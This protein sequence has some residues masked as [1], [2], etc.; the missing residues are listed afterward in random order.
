MAANRKIWIGVGVA[1][2]VAAILAVVLIAGG[3]DEASAQTVTFQKPTDA[4]PDP[5][6]KPSDIHGEDT[7]DVGSG[8]YG[9]T[10]S[11]LVCDRELL[12][13]SLKARPD[14]LREWAK[15]LNVTPTYEAVARYIRSLR[16]VTLTRDTRV[17]NYSFEG[18]KAVGFQS[19]LQA[20]T[21]VLVD[22]YGEP[23]VRCRC[24]NPLTKPIYYP[25]AKCY[26]CPP[27]YEPPPPCEPYS[28]CWH[29]YP[30]PPPVSTSEEPT[31]D[32]QRKSGNPSAYFS[33]SAGTTGDTY[34]LYA[35][36]F[37][38]NKTLEVT[39]TR[40]DG[41]VE[42]YSIKTN[43]SGSGSYTFGQ[44][45]DVVLGT[46]TA[47]VK[48]PSS[49]GTA[50][51]S[52]HVSEKKSEGDEQDTQTDTQTETTPQEQDPQYETPPPDDGSGD[53]GS[54]AY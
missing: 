3:S 54:P 12:I 43:S 40:P 37:G 44:T 52:T 2:L 38:A 29:K 4:G 42:N 32:Q 46:Y 30:T 34:T 35:S 45:S 13:R 1:A 18:G 53:S 15:V 48:D 10:G 11:D 49:G 8:P 28:E 33:P 39:L 16:P 36:G 41:V 50:T 5:F 20:G 19:I 7:V 51:A 25:S 31:G 17:T 9:G 22:K 21:A 6:T 47:V 27:N 24:G 14:R 26:G 23:V